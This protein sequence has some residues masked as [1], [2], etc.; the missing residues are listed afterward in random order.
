M[1]S[2]GSAPSCHRGPAGANGRTAGSAPGLSAGTAGVF[3]ATSRGSALESRGAGLGAGDRDSRAAGWSPL[4][5]PP[6]QPTGAAHV[7]PRQRRQRLDRRARNRGRR[8]DR[9]LHR[10]CTDC[11]AVAFGGADAFTTGGGSRGGAGGLDIGIDFTAGAV[12]TARPGALPAVGFPRAPDQRDPAITGGLAEARESGAAGAGRGGVR[13]W[14]RPSHGALAAGASFDVGHRCLRRRRGRRRNVRPVLPAG[15][16]VAVSGAAAD[17]FTTGDAASW[18]QRCTHR[19]RIRLWCL[20]IRLWVLRWHAHRGRRLRS[21]QADSTLVSSDSSFWVLRWRAHRGRRY[22]HRGRIRPWFLRIRLWVLRWHAHRGRWY[23]HRRRIRLW[24]LRRYAHRG[25]F[26]SG[27]FGF[28]S[29]ISSLARSP[30]AQV[31]SPQARRFVLGRRRCDRHLRRTP[32][33]AASASSE[34]Q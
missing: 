4:E 13:L 1:R 22:A 15:G 23:A 24:V 27:L 8:R 31:R 6:A 11:G 29:G 2:A 19:R 7:R 20:R 21:P 26:D 30:R 18:Q 10:G 9:L 28:D 32:A 16:G 3:S 5:P 33:R 25:R 34:Y 12:A 17:A 14:R